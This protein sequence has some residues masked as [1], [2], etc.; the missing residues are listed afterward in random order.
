M[1]GRGGHVSHH[2]VTI[3]SSKSAVVRAHLFS[4]VSCCA[5]ALLLTSISCCARALFSTCTCVSCFTPRF[6]IP[7]QLSGVTKLHNNHNQNYIYDIGPSWISRAQL[8]SSRSSEVG[9]QE[10]SANLPPETLTNY[11]QSPGT[12]VSVRIQPRKAERC[13]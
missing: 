13:R 9:Q 6:C 8:Y 3:A 12:D 4:F 10:D 5:R 11:L 7:L 2:S 1:G